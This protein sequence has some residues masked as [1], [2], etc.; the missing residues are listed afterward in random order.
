M[1][2]LIPRNPERRSSFADHVLLHH[3]GTKIIRAVPQRNLTYLWALSDPRALDIL[4]S[5]PD[6]CE[7]E[8]AFAGTRPSRPE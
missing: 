8:P 7:I 1:L 5:C 2:D 4:D 3:D 6:K